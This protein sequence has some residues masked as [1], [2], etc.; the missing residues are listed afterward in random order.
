MYVAVPT[1]LVHSAPDSPKRPLV[2]IVG[3]AK[4]STK[5]PVLESL[6]GAADAILSGGAM[7]FTFVKARGGLIGNSLCEDDML[8]MAFG[9]Q[10]TSRLGCQIIAAE[11]LDGIE[12]Q[13]PTFTRNFYVDGHVPEPH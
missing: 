5:L 13:L 11:N 6:L 1:Q 4:V 10:P 3:G 9:L 8:D 7:A 12:L 2:A